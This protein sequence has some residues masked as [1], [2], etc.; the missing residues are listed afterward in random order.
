[1]IGT[2]LGHHLGQPQPGRWREHRLQRDPI[3]AAGP[4]G[5]TRWEPWRSCSHSRLGRRSA[6]SPWSDNSP[7]FWCT[8]ISM[9]LRRCVEILL[10]DRDQSRRLVPSADNLAVLMDA[11]LTAPM[12]TNR[13]PGVKHAHRHDR[14]RDQRIENVCVSSRRRNALLMRLSGLVSQ[15]QEGR[16][17]SNVIGI[18]G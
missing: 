14:T 3:S 12:G 15:T 18:P 16:S 11:N 17:M 6:V 5:L 1:M 7:G 8:R 10:G 2:D 9:F 4:F 13:R